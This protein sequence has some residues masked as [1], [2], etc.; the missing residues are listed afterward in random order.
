[1][2]LKP[3]EAL[4]A[5]KKWPGIRMGYMSAICINWFI[6][7]TGTTISSFLA[8]NSNEFR[9]TEESDVVVDQASKTCAAVLALYLALV[10]VPAVKYYI[11]LFFYIKD[12]EIL[13]TSHYSEEFTMRRH[14]GIRNILDLIPA[15]FMPLLPNVPYYILWVLPM[16]LIYV[17]VKAVSVFMTMTCGSSEAMMKY[18]KR[19][20]RFYARNVFA[21]NDRWWCSWMIRNVHE[22]E[23]V[24]WAPLVKDER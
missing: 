24:G 2:I 17:A 4:S 9:C 6:V 22:D 3:Y 23:L 5:P 1:M 15:L 20:D 18:E 10:L 19:F 8:T 11:R 13:A 12:I 14:A 21:L 7:L 16:G